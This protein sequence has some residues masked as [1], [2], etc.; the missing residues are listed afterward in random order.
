[1]TKAELG[2]SRS[3]MGEANAILAGLV[4][5][6]IHDAINGGHLGC[7]ADEKVENFLW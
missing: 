2:Y 6:K 1:M 4:S 7:T 3:L 5:T